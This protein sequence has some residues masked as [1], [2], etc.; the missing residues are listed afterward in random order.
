MLD[1]RARKIMKIQLNEVRNAITHKILVKFAVSSLKI[2]YLA[3][4]G[5]NRNGILGM[6]IKTW[7]HVL[8]FLLKEIEKKG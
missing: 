5:Q 2:T 4:K 1:K 7:I 3:E 8:C 6:W